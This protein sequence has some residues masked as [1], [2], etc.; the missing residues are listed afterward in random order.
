[1][2]QVDIGADSF[3][4]HVVSRD[5]T[6]VAYARRVTNGDRFGIECAGRS[7]TE[8]IE[9]MTRWLEW[10]HEHAAALESLRSAEQAYHRTVAGTAFT[11]SPGVEDDATERRDRLDRMELA[12]AEL[13][14]V[15]SRNP[16]R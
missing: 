5:E 14:E 9:R 2:T 13:D 16:D 3:T 11:A 8:A 1:M 6:C 4:L 7:E 12:R 15:R 10:Q